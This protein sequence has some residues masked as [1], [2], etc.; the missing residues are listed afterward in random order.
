[1]EKWGLSFFAECK[2]EAVCDTV[3]WPSAQPL[4]CT[5]ICTVRRGDARL[6]EASPLL[7]SRR[8]PV[9]KVHSTGWEIAISSGEHEG[10]YCV[11]E[12][13]HDSLYSVL[14]R[15]NW[16]TDFDRN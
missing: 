8:V 1:M 2:K 5:V 11:I 15:V 13:S 6:G 7:G 3:S 14:L 4:G 12:C 9:L 16:R 10:L